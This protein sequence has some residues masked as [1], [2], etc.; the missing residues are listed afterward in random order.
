MHTCYCKCQ[1]D[2]EINISEKGNNH[3]ANMHKVQL[4]Y[5]C[6][7]LIEPDFMKTTVKIKTLV[8]N[9]SMHFKSAL[10]EIFLRKIY[11]N[12]TGYTKNKLIHNTGSSLTA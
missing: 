6:N 3:N 8:V 5:I 2:H 10:L 4:D 11:T 1:N 9:G 12:C 7:W